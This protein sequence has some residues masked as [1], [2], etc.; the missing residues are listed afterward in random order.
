MVVSLPNTSEDSFLLLLDRYG[1]WR[2][3]SIINGF[4][5]SLGGLASSYSTTGD[6]AFIGKNKSDILLAGKRLKEIGGG[7]VLVN[8]GEIIYELKLELNGTMF[9]GGMQAL[10]QKERELN[11]ILADYGYKYENPVFNLL[12]LSATQLP[13]F[14]MIQQAI[15]SLLGCELHFI[16]VRSI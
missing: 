9:I 14:R 11:T 12:F 4:T 1:K 15:D 16:V 8:Q 7:I 10:I 6:I 3:N 5:T 13:Y 2:V